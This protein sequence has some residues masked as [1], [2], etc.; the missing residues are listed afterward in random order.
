MN[1]RSNDGSLSEL[2]SKRLSAPFSE[3]EMIANAEE[4]LGRLDFTSAEEIC[5]KVSSL[6]S[7]CDEV[8]DRA[9]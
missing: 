5:T 9:A 6:I 4:A 3:V 7:L 2:A 8:R 1:K